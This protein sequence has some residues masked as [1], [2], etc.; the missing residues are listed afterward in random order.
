MSQISTASMIRSYSNHYALEKLIKCK[1]TLMNEWLEFCDKVYLYIALFKFISYGL[2]II[3]FNVT[4]E[5]IAVPLST[6]GLLINFQLPFFRF[7]S[8]Y[9]RYKLYILISTYHFKLITCI[10]KLFFVS[11]I[12]VK[13]D[14]AVI[15]FEI[16]LF[17]NLYGE[18]LLDIIEK[19]RGIIFHIIYLEFLFSV[20]F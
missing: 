15:C 18:K 17:T 10:E 3:L 7:I 19:T 11:L 20:L 9:L 1:S 6:L 14:K 5:L 8:S 13:S 4:R 2:E 16:M 12:R